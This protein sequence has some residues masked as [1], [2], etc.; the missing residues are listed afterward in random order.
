MMLLRRRKALIFSIKHGNC[1]PNQPLNSL[2][3]L[4]Q[5]PVVFQKIIKKLDDYQ[6]ALE[7][8]LIALEA[9]KDELQQVCLY[10]QES[11]ITNL[12]D[13]GKCL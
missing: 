1:Y 2:S 10:G 7:W 4:R 13:I 5:S 3:P 8:M 6:K 11:F 9:R 12:G